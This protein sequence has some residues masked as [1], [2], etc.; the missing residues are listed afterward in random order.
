MNKISSIQGI[1]LD[2]IQSVLK[3][4]PNT[5][6][7]LTW[8]PRKDTKWNGR[9]ANKMAGCIQISKKDGYKCYRVTV[10]YNKKK[11]YLICSRIIFLL[12]Y[13]YLTEHKTIDHID[14]NSLNNKINNLREITLFENSHN[15]KKPKNNTSGNKGVSWNKSI[16]MWIVRIGYK[17]KRYYFGCYKNKKDAIKVA[18][19]ARK[20][21]HGEF[22][23]DI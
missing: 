8:L 20:K 11:L 19:E 3:I 16:K 13:G 1:P 9:F 18:I 12:Y 5:S 14:G 23:R 15:R 10:V 7:G 17:N 6:S 2:Y 22:G 4:D 21:L